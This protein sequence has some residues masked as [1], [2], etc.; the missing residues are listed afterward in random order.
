LK[1][2]NL[3]DA[4]NPVNVFGDTGRPDYSLFLLRHAEQA[5]DTFYDVPVFYSEP[6]RIQIGTRIS[7]N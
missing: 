3:F 5:D 7:F 1:V 4:D 2:F 6:R